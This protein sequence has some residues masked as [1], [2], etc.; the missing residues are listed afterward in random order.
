MRM[1]SAPVLLLTLI[2]VAS[3]TRACGLNIAITGTSQGIGLDAARRLLADGHQVYHACRTK[4][5]ADVA[6]REAGGGFPMVCDLADLNSVRSFADALL[7]EA[8]SLDVLCLNAAVAPSR[9]AAE[10]RLTADG[11]E[12]C[13][14]TNHLGHYLLAN[15]LRERLAGGVG[16]RLVVTASSVHDPEAPGGTVKGEG[17]ATLGDLSG[18]GVR[19]DR[20]PGGATMADG[21]EKYDGG[22]VYNDSKLCNVLFCREALKRW[23]NG[24][25]GKIAVRS[26]NPGFIPSSGLFREPRKN[27][28]LGATA[29]TFVAGLVGFAVPIEVGGERL[30]YMATADDSEVPPGAYYS[31]EVG[32]KAATKADGFGPAAISKEASSDALAAQLWDR[33]AEI[34]GL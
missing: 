3:A 7:E 14:G 18:L 5:R 9:K 6:V 8:P 27:N 20:T 33:S 2:L 22:K 34:V 10:P 12:D 17:G 4:E 11:F 31:A 30:A 21:A 28:W 24:G 16:G 26:F 32:S 29:F 15:L 1:E 13:I 19:L 23:G 25:G